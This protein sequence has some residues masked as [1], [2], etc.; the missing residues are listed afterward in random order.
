MTELSI[1]CPW[2]CHSCPGWGW[3]PRQVSRQAESL[4][5]PGSLVPTL[6]E[7]G[8]P[9]MGHE[10]DSGMPCPHSNRPLDSCLGTVVSQ[11]PEP[12]VVRTH[13]SP[14]VACAVLRPVSP[15]GRRPGSRSD[16][17]PRAG[18]ARRRFRA[19]AC[20]GGASERSRPGLS[21]ASAHPRRPL[22]GCGSGCLGLG[23]AHLT[24]CKHPG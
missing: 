5:A 19:G 6:R 3:R 18:S 16:D 23:I 12:E 4:T 15:A 1:N 17:R 11:C 13:P 7:P 8:A 2:A 24:C 14:V 20:R 22:A 9:C 21:G 10:G